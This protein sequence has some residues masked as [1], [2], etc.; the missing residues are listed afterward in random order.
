MRT[1]NSIRFTSFRKVREKE[2]EFLIFFQIFMNRFRPN[3]TSYLPNKA[4]GWYNRFNAKD[5]FNLNSV[6]SNHENLKK[7]Q[8]KVKNS[9]L[10]L[11]KFSL[12]F[13]SDRFDFDKVRIK[14]ESFPVLLCQKIF[15]Y[16]FILEILE[17]NA[18]LGRKKSNILT[19]FN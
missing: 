13:T 10:V 16:I 17:F 15:L 12:A 3:R 19:F 14:F 7:K 2:F 8:K 6:W 9:K 4:F 18:S 1:R 11:Q 5:T